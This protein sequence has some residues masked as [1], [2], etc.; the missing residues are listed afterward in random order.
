MGTTKLGI[1]NRAL[2]MAGER[3]LATLSDEVDSRRLLDVIWDFGGVDECLSEGQWNFAMRSVQVDFDP[4]IE[5]TFGYIRAFTKPS[6]YLLT[7]AF[8]SDEFYRV[9]HRWYV[10][11]VDNWY[12]DL[13]IIYVR[14]I[15]NDTDYGGDLGKWPP[16]FSEFVAAHFAA[17]IILKLTGDATRLKLFVNPENEK[18]S[19]RGRALLSAKSRNAMANPSQII[20][21]GAWSSSRIRGGTRWDRGSQN[22]LIG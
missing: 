5:P 1:Y 4:A 21:G 10:D 14:Y 3:A 12:C 18:D 2:T 6:D 22:N 19:I 13:D 16:L 7:S 8:C 11:E 20:A 17:G 9:P 15:S